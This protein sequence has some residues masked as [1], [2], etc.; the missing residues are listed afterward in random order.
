MN[1]FDRI[2]VGVDGTD[3]GYEA[4]HQTLALAPTGASVHAVTA[5]NTAQLVHAG[6][7]M[8]HFMTQ[9]EEEAERARARATEIMGDRPDCTAKVVRGDAKAVLRHACD[10]NEATLVALGGRSSSR[11]LGMMAGE[12]AATLLHDAA[13]SVLFARPQWGQRWHPN[14]VV[15][16]LDGSPYSLAALTVADDLA[17]RLGSAIQVVTA[18]GGKSISHE[19]AW[20]ERVTEWD[21]GHPSGVLR[22]RSVLTDLLIL[23]S[24]GLHGVRALGSVSE[25]VAHRAHCSTLVVHPSP[26]N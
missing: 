22:D 25:R 9:F 5:L 19:G 24:R 21:P 7:N 3:F 8:E 11:F 20:T 13:R 14:R 23:G 4:L 2:A 18:T 10:E 26:P 6:F 17:A 15:V 1:V 12:T 16:G